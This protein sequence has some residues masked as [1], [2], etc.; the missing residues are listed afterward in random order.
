MTATS[1]ERPCYR[2]LDTPV[3][4]LGLE[5]GDWMVIVVASSVCLLG[6]ILCD[7]WLGMVLPFAVWIVLVRLRKGKRPPGYLRYVAYRTGLRS[8][9]QVLMR[10][11]VVAPYL[12]PAVWALPWRSER[13]VFLSAQRLPGDSRSAFIRMF[14]HRRRWVLEELGRAGGAR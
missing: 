3:R 5:V 4:V 8:L 14:L 7:L 2:A 1:W 11:Y 9:L 6:S 13:R 10:E 12:P